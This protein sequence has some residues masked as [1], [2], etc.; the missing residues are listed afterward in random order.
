[1]ERRTKQKRL[2]INYNR[3]AREV[4]AAHEGWIASPG[5][6]EEI[7]NLSQL[8]Y[9]LGQLEDSN[10]ERFET[11]L[12]F[13]TEEL[14]PKLNAVVKSRYQ[15]LMAQRRDYKAFVALWELIRSTRSNGWH[16]APHKVL[17]HLGVEKLAYPTDWNDLVARHYDTPA[18][19]T[20]RNLP[21]RGPGD[22]R[23][24]AAEAIRT[25]D[26]TQA[27]IALAY[28]NCDQHYRLTAGD[29]LT[30]ELAKLVMRHRARRTSR[31]KG[32][33]HA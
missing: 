2:Q 15:E 1:M 3:Y 20:F 28:C 29:I 33:D 18:I 5:H 32:V 4:K 13:K 14:K 22:V 10:R 30:A 24:L 17:G 23:L 27:Q 6:E 19:S 7:V 16:G 25:N 12:A 8:I 11:K 21:D 9:L 26:F 31:R